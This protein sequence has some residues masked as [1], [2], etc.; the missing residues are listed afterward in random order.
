MRAFPIRGK[1]R[2]LLY[3]K[4]LHTWPVKSTTASER[5]LPFYHAVWS[6]RKCSL[7]STLNTTNLDYKQPG[8]PISAAEQTGLNSFLWVHSK[9]KAP[10]YWKCPHVNGSQATTVRIHLVTTNATVSTF[11]FSSVGHEVSSAALDSM[12]VTHIILRRGKLCLNPTLHF[13][14]F[15]TVAFSGKAI[16]EWANQPIY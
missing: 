12:A 14:F 15:E 10:W 9:L 16:I 2:N 5:H 8:C 3:H 11:V 1:L 7:V 4:V 13:Q 6:K